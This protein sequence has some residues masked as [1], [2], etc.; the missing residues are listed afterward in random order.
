MEDVNLPAEPEVPQQEAPPAEPETPPEPQVETIPFKVRGEERQLRADAVRLLAEDLGYDDPQAVVNQLQMA[1]DAAEVYRQARD[2]Y[3][4]SRAPQQQSDEPQYQPQP[5]YQPP[6][7][8]YRPPQQAEDDP[9]AL[10]RAIHAEMRQ[11]AEQQRQMYEAMQYQQQ[12]TAFALQQQAVKLMR[13]EE[14]AYHGFVAEL[15]KDGVPDYRIPERE[16]ILEE[17]ESMGLFNSGL[18]PEELYR[19]T[20]RMLYADDIA[21]RAAAQALQKAR[22]PKATVVVP[23]ARAAAPPPPPAANTIAGMEAQ[24]GGMKMSDII[25]SIPHAR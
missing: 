9:V 24:L 22:S 18:T 23:G 25:D 17:A 15:R 2:L 10:V 19:R 12:Q 1:K 3:K 20:Y 5:Q 16:M 6:E 8:Q 21:E 4:R 11:V 7:P 13:E 14:K